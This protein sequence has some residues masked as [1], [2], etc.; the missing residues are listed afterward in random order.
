MLRVLIVDDAADVR[1]VW[2]EWLTIWGF[3]QYAVVKGRGDPAVAREVTW[4]ATLFYV[5]GLGGTR[6]PYIFPGLE[7]M[8]VNFGRTQVNLPSR[9]AKPRPHIP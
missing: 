2:R 5:V 4:H 6:D 8:W 9:G 3:G 1:E 7:N